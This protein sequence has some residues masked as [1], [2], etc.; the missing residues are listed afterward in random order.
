M[1]LW[2]KSSGCVG[3]HPAT[4]IFL[5]VCL[6]LTVTQVDGTV[7]HLM[8]V[9]AVGIAL[10]SPL[11]RRFLWRTRFLFIA[12]GLVLPWTTPGIYA[13]SALG[14]FSPTVE[15]LLAASGQLER[16]C[17]VLVGLSLA[18][19]RLDVAGRLCAVISFM[20]PLA[21]AGLP[22]ERLAVRLVL[23]LQSLEQVPPRRRWQDWRN[24]WSEALTAEVPPVVLELDLGR[25]RLCDYLCVVVAVVA[26]GG[27]VLC[28][29]P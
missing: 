20:Q 11:A 27:I 28:V 18:M 5:W 25:W 17:I 3:L 14:L 22:V 6:A 1:G 10:M 29:G 19:S 9:T 8:A 13:V 24:A 16:S 7:L 23:T 2:L 12:L 4:R 26:V 21:R 15:G